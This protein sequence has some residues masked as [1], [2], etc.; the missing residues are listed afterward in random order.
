MLAASVVSR[1]VWSGNMARCH[2]SVWCNGIPRA[3]LAPLPAPPWSLVVP[4]RPPHALGFVRCRV[5]LAPPPGVNV[6]GVIHQLQRPPGGW[7]A[8]DRADRV[9]LARWRALGRVQ[10]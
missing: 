5:Q 10:V 6:E 2:V 8:V 3:R 4:P 9:M 1:V 7:V